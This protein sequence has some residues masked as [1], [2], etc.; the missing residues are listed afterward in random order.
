MLATAMS[1]RSQ[2]ITRSPVLALALAL[3]LLL[4]QQFGLQHGVA[5]LRGGPVERW[6]TTA[7]S[8]GPAVRGKVQVL[9]N[10]TS[11]AATAAGGAG[12]AS[13]VATAVSTDTTSDGPADT[14]CPVC[15]V[16]AAIGAATLVAVLRWLI[17]RQTG[18]VPSAPAGR[19]P[20]RPARRQHHARAPPLVLALS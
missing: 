12:V 8:A 9:G 18:S 19:P 14:L 13:T 16:L 15:L 17:T 4:T 3:V 10:A 1:T 11:P 2:H 20:A 6:S 5:H 7:P